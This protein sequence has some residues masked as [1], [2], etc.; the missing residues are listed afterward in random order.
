M[1]SK[2]T[3]SEA[4]V[5]LNRVREAHAAIGR[6]IAQT[7]ISRKNRF[8]ELLN[9]YGHYAALLNISETTALALHADGVGTKVLIAQMM[10]KYDTVGIDCVAMNVNDLICCGAEPAA[11]VDYL[12]LE[13]SNP[14]LAE[15]LMKGLVKGA[16][17]S[18]IAVV[19]GETAIMP[20]VIKGV[21]PGYGFDLAALSIGV[22]EKANV[23]LGDKVKVGDTVI[24][25]RSSGPHS[26]GYTLIRKIIQRENI[27]L[28]TTLTGT[29][30]KL[31]E[32]LL[33]PTKIY[34][35]EVLALVEAGL[36]SGLAHITGGAFTKLMR[37]TK[38]RIGFDIEMPKPDGVFTSLQEWGRVDTAEMYRTFNMGIGF[39]IITPPENECEALKKIS[40]AG[41][42]AQVLGHTIREA[43][44]KI[45]TYDDKILTY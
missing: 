16:K 3:Y 27:P 29:S 44:V 19:G 35:K 39:C 42:K 31:G 36:A 22:V 10:D 40:A 32:I 23:I 15:Q 5:D 9:E 25:I 26:N 28:N 17:Q 38:N 4:G 1:T 18:N 13:S 14:A 34:V 45:K 8:G 2:I 43:K 6:L 12:A 33:T 20:D 41:S 7:F 11:L 24:G 21:K 37:I 30:K